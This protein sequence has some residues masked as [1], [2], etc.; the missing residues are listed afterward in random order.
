M[1][2]LALNGGRPVRETPSSKWPRATDADI[3]AVLQAL[4]EGSWCRIGADRA[5]RFEQE[6]AAYQGARFGVAVNSGTSALELGL[7]ALGIQP[8]DEVILP[9]YTFMA[10]ASS[11]LVTRGIPIFVDIDPD[12]YNIDPGR[13]EEAITDRSFAI[14]PVHFGGRACD[15]DRILEIARRHDL[16]VI[17]DAC[18][19]HGAKWMDRGLGTVAD[20]GAFSCGSGKNLS[21]GEGGILLTDTEEVYWRAAELHDLWTGGL[22]QRSGDWGGGSFTSGTQWT[23]PQAAPNYRLAEILAVLLSSELTRLDE[24]TQARADNGTYLKEILDATPGVKTL[25]HDPFV[26]RDSRHIFI[27]KYVGDGFDDLPRS[28]FAKALAA[29]G[30]PASMGYPR[31]CHRHPV[32]LDRE[33]Q[34]T[35]PYNR[36][37]TEVPIDY[38]SMAC[39]RCDYLCENETVWLAGSYMLDGGRDGMEQVGEAIEKIRANRHELAESAASV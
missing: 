18:H 7:L 16:K 10:S 11:V 25:R 8:G 32:F 23:F 38:A 2:K 31:G 12:T 26:T 29:E 35:W 34:R 5:H 19:A 4:K 33:G 1:G 27:F 21:A 20:V 30:I 22:V 36:L 28:Q 17:E 3:E 15:M 37:L 13:I 39:P 14:M 9:P 24:E 6:F